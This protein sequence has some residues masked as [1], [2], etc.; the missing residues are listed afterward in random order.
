MGSIVPLE[1]SVEVAV[2]FQIEIVF[3]QRLKKANK[4]CLADVRNRKLFSLF[5]F[6][7][8]ANAHMRSEK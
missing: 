8:T 3:G 2:T 7:D 1:C 5:M 6:A 4:I